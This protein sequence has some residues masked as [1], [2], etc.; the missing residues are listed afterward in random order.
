MATDTR[1]DIVHRFFSGNAAS[2]DRIIN[3]FT[4]GCDRYWKRLILERCLP[5]AERVL[6][7]ACG[8]GILTFALARRSPEAE[9]VGV[10]IMP[11]YLEIARRRA[12]EGG[13]RNV[14]FIHA[15]AEEVVLDGTFDCITGSYLAKYA[16]LDLLVRKM[17][18]LLRPGGILILHDFTYPSNPL[19][20]WA[21]EVYLGMLRLIGPRLFPEWGSAFTE[22]ADFMRRSTWVPDLRAAMEKHGFSQIQVE[23]LSYGTA[24]IIS[25]VRGQAPASPSG[26]PRK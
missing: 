21:W 25:G 23:R 10:D 11:E 19:V 8:T 15:R 26:P 13:F 16:D 17:A 4:L 3:L 20:A 1:V 7:L 22:L 12:A 5:R 18:S 24:A 6:D 14:S 2:Y 9:I